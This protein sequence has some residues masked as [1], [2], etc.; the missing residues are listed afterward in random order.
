MRRALRADGVVVS[1]REGTNGG[2]ST[3]WELTVAYRDATGQERQAG[4]RGDSGLD[5]TRYA[6]GTPVPVRYDPRDPSWVWLPGGGRV[7][8]VLLPAALTV[9]GAGIVVGFLLVS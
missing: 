4:W 3:P 9:V 2:E 8:P 7:H 6:P 5:R 1:A